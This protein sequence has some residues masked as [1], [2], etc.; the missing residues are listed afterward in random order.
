MIKLGRIAALMAVT[1]SLL[2]IAGI[3]ADDAAAPLKP[4][5]VGR[6]AVGYLV[7]QSG[8]ARNIQEEWTAL[9]GKAKEFPNTG[10]DKSDVKMSQYT[11]GAGDSVTHGNDDK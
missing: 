11:T 1:C 7:S 9:N 6:V 4:A 10:E 2:A 8:K 3:A 5:V